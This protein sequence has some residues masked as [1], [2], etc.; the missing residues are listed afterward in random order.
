MAQA[1]PPAGAPNIM[2]AAGGTQLKNIFED[3]GI[4][5]WT[6]HVDWT[7][8][9]NTK[10]SEA[11]KIPVAPYH[12]LCDGQ[13]S[14]CVPQPDTTRRLDAQGD[15][16]MQRLVYRN[17]GGR[18]SIVAIH[19]VNSSSRARAACAGTSSG[20]T[21]SASR[22][23]FNRARTLPMD[24]TAGWAARLWT[25]GATSESVIPSAALL[26]SRGSGL[27]A[28]MADDPPGVL[29]FH[30]TVLAEGEASQTSGNRWEDYTTTAMDPS[31]DCTFWYVGDYLKKGAATYSTRIGAFRLPGCLRGM[32]GGVA[33]MDLNHDGTRQKDEPAIQGREIAYSG[34]ESGK[35]TTDADGAFSISLP[36]DP[37]YADPVYTVNSKTIHLKA[38]DAIAVDFPETCTVKSSGARDAK[39]WMGDKGQNAVDHH[40]GEWKKLINTLYLTTPEGTRFLPKRYSQFRA[41]LR[42]PPSAFLAAQA[43]AGLNADVGT[44]D[45]KGSVQDPVVKDWVTIHSLIKRVSDAYLARNKGALD[46][47]KPLLDQL[48]NNTATITPSNAAAC[49]GK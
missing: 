39:F 31:D 25:S 17:I 32:I 4:Y 10:V 42:K 5:Y 48:N 19:S 46:A 13:L 23:C 29:S 21:R 44:L 28:R 30:E 12:Y 41:W 16:I 27:P 9:K 15:K 37:L 1:V 47:Y 3:D 33:Y 35:V 20:W 43:V 18:E 34:A 49:A 8:P 38:G 6:F 45:G 22:T 2:M 14:N 24:S 26:T 40:Y 11:V 36:A 7:N